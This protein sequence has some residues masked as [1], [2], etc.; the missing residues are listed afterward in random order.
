MIIILLF[1]VS[2]FFGGVPSSITLNPPKKCFFFLGGGLCWDPR[3]VM[4][5]HAGFFFLNLEGLQQLSRPNTECT[6]CLSTALVSLFFFSY[7][8]YGSWWL[9]ISTCPGN[10]A[11]NTDVHTK[12]TMVLCT[13][14]ICGQF[15]CPFS[16]PYFFLGVTVGVVSPSVHPWGWE[17]LGQLP[18]GWLSMCVDH[19]RIRLVC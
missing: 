9:N 3:V 13:W 6:A 8:R 10:E 11:T 5:K 16:A 2:H 18:H 14:K 7:V 4:N 12:C 1:F 19:I 15:R 17:G